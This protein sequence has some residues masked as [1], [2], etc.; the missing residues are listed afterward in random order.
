MLML[1]YGL[2]RA[3]LKADKMTD[4]MNCS[5]GCN[6][7]DAVLMQSQRLKGLKDKSYSS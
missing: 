2:L 1:L 6:D 7:T 5:N 3:E 4:V